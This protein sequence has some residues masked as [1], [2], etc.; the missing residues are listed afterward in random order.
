[1]ADSLNG[2]AG[3]AP[4]GR[5]TIE[6][7]GYL[8][9]TGVL[10]AGLEHLGPMPTT[11]ITLPADQAKRDLVG[12]GLLTESGTRT[13]FASSVLSTIMAPDEAWWGV[14]LLRSMADATPI[15]VPEELK[16]FEGLAESI[17]TIPKVFFTIA[18]SGATCAIAVRSGMNVSVATVPARGD[19]NSQVADLLME[20]LNPQRQW[21]PAADWAE[22]V[23][24]HEATRKYGR[25]GPTGDE[26]LDAQI[27]L[28]RRK[29]YQAQGMSEGDVDRA[30][31]LLEDTSQCAASMQVQHRDSMGRDTP[32]AISIELLYGQGM[33]VIYPTLGFDRA[34][35]LRMVRAEHRNVA[36]AAEAIASMPHFTFEV[37][38]NA[39]S[40]GR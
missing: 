24:P 5:L 7:V 29:E 15:E 32:S 40:L 36:L 21:E 33:I 38:S 23:V 37:Q 4:L 26:R 11:R 34:W 35:W 13:Q 25:M 27:R 2:I 16:R 20:I 12:H 31:R 22:L 3:N 18:Y 1:M 39:A 19:R 17:M 6:H 10:T 9:E 30:L 14:I 28:R 8:W